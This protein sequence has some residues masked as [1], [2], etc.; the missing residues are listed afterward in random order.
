MGGEKD[1]F[2]DYKMF[3]ALKNLLGIEYYI[4]FQFISFLNANR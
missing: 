4:H 2:N 1:V 3:L